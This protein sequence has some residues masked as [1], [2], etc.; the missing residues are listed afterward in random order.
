M[1][2][3][4]YSQVIKRAIVAALVSEAVSFAVRRYVVP[5]AEGFLDGEETS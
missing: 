3:L 4:T 5:L 1:Q 2:K